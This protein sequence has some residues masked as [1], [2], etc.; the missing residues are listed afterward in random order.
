MIAD[1]GRSSLDLLGIFFIMVSQI[2]TVIHV[3]M[4]QGCAAS[5]YEKVERAANM[6]EKVYTPLTASILHRTFFEIVTD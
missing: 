5:G 3:D 6:V 4:L 2:F 1:Y